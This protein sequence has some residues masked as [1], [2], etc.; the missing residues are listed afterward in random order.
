[1][2]KKSKQ[3]KA[4]LRDFEEVVKKTGKESY[5][6]KLYVTGMTPRSVKAIENIRRDM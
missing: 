5:V 3:E 2:D 1:M 4:E 6:L